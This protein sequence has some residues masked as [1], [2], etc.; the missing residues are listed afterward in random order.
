M[1][2]SD[3]ILGI[4]K[5]LVMI[6]AGITIVFVMAVLVSDQL[7]LPSL[8]LVN[9]W[10]LLIVGAFT[11]VLITFFQAQVFPALLLGV[12]AYFLLQKIHGLLS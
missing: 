12:T 2:D 9:S 6:L 3:K 4:P 1:N 7:C 8:C 5:K 11:L 10:L